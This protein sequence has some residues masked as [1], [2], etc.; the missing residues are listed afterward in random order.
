MADSKAKERISRSKFTR[1]KRYIRV[2]MIFIV[3]SLISVAAGLY[4]SIT[5][6]TRYAKTYREDTLK[7]AAVLAAS[8]VNPYRM[9]DW[10]AEG[11]DEEFER[12]EKQLQQILD[13]TPFLQNLYLVQIEKDG[14][15][16]LCALTTNDTDINHEARM[17]P[18]DIEFGEVFPFDPAFNEYVPT[19]LAG[20]RPEIIEVR[21]DDGWSLLAYEPIYT[22]LNECKGYIGVDISMNG[23]N[24][25]INT[26]TIWVSV[27]SI[28]FLC[29][30]GLAGVIITAYARRADDLDVTAE[31]QEREQKLLQELIESYAQVVDAKDPYTNG[32]SSRVAEYAVKIAEL[33][34]KSDE[35]CQQIYFTALLHDVGKVGI[36]D[37]II[38][39]PGKLTDEEFNII[40]QHPEKGN[41]I[42][43][44]I[45][46]FSYLS[47]GAHFHHERYDGKGYPNGLKGKDIPEIA[48]IIAC[49]DAYDAMT[50]RRS[51]RDPI[52]QHI[53][54]EEF[55]KGIGTQFDPEFAR[56]M[57]HL[58]D[59]DAEYAMKDRGENKELR[60]NNQLLLTYHRSAITPGILLGNSLT[61]VKVTVNPDS[62]TSRNKPKPSI[63]LFDSLDGHLHE[64]EK[65]KKEMLDFEYGEIW[66]GGRHSVA[67]ARKMES[68]TEEG[69][70]A[71]K[72]KYTIE[73][74]RIK[75]HA[76]VRIK[77]SNGKEFETIVALPDSSRFVYLGLTG[78]H[79]LITDIDITKSEDE[80]PESY[81]PRIA[82]KISY[83]DG[84]EG[85]LPNVEMDGYRTDSTKGILL[86]DNLT[87]SFHTMSLPT[88]RLVWHCPFISIFSSNDGTIGGKD[89]RELTLM[90]LDG[91][92]WEGDPVCS[93]ELKVTKTSD[94]T[95]WNTWKAYNHT[96]Y[97]VT[98]NIVR[99]GD[100]I[101]TT[102]TNGGISIHATTIMNAD[103]DPI[104]IAL[105]GDQCAIT[106][107]KIRNS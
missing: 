28:I 50:S 59:L 91:E 22:H 85:D 51:Y 55:V 24:N 95:D 78:E 84:P 10:I 6:F 57:L 7:K 9:D 88:A 40:K 48:R 107:I 3:L 25:Y 19:F 86:K 83:I 67:G 62:P 102:T 44:Q 72:G 26:F 101:H 92:C 68:T 98:V 5:M 61:T 74:A 52:P 69:Y 43:S 14:F 41:R 93:M 60:D 1:G 18:S 35:E 17:Q 97:D 20:G 12:T 38:N 2:L 54:R 96:G 30:I 49:A 13:N 56:T 89:F 73:A 65:D 58:I 8:E 66:F 104:Y 99:E 106:N 32:H 36:P 46:E 77:G 75:D 90:R 103:V 34:G 94:F 33:A 21:D 80:L 105:T 100:K 71:S 81:I 53:V 16:T 79:C 39:K 64:L 31:Q 29:L 87:V 70:N 27:I 76:I 45:D 23:V 47:V 4:L 42:L 63:V 11:P 37:A 82:E 15:H